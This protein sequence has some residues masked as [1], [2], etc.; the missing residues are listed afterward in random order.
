MLY[1][2]Q[3]LF[4]TVLMVLIGVVATLSASALFLHESGFVSQLKGNNPV[5]ESNMLHSV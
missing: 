3:K 1:N 5:Y 2:Y 4:K